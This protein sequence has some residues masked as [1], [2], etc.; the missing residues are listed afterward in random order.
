MTIVC[1]DSHTATHGAFGALAFGIGTSEVEHVLATQTLPAGPGPKWMAVEVEGELPARR[2]RQGR[3]PRRHRPR[4]AP[5]AASAMSSSTAGRGD[6]RPLD[7]RPD[8]GLQHV[9]RGGRARRAGRA[10]RHDLRLPRGP[11]LR[12]KGAALGARRST[13]GRTLP[14]GRRR[15]LGQPGHDRR[16][17]A[18]PHVTWGTNPGQVAT[19]DG[20]VPTRTRSPS[21]RA[22][23]GV[24]GPHLHGPH[25]RARRCRTSVPTRCSSARART[26]ASRTCGRRPHVLT[27]AG[28]ACRGCM[29]VPGSRAVKAQAEEEGLDT[30]PRRRRRLAGAWLLHV[31][32]HE[33]R[34]A[35]RPASGRSHLEPQL[36]GPPGQGRPHP[37]RLT[38]GGRRDRRRRPLRTP[39]DLA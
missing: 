23:G 32:R 30:L 4:S 9:H 1:G 36:R 33:P 5:A 31:P 21:R 12:P 29:V 24:A 8:D 16:R 28:R 10:G 35:R 39:E 14:I 13:T 37:P 17:A 2:D 25:A 7:G 20:A 15:G 18:R 19:I 3:H 22:R 26:R 11:P 27:A 38:R 34:Q 6:P